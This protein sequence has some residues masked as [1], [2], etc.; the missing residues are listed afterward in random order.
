MAWERARTDEQKEVRVAEIMEATAR[1]Y[2]THS[3]EDINLSLIAKEAKFTRSN[4]YKYF[5]SKEEIFLEFIKRDFG[6]W[7]LDFQTAYERDRTYTVREFAEIW[8]RTFINHSRFLSLQAILYTVLE[9][10]VSVESLVNFKRYLNENVGTV[11]DLICM[12]LPNCTPGKA[13]EFIS[14][15]S[16]VASGLYAATRLSDVQRQVLEMPEFEH[17]RIDFTIAFQDAVEYLLRGVLG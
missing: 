11:V 14:L 16:A 1:L 7:L 2:E 8:V 17:Y 10:N 4:L 9:K 5:S 12:A 6:I 3:F 13:S 15:Q